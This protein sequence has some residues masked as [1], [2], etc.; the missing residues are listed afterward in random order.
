MNLFI[1]IIKLN[2]TFWGEDGIGK[3]LQRS[4]DVDEI[5]HNT[6]DQSALNLILQFIQFLR[7][8]PEHQSKKKH[9]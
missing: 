7:Q 6:I 9:H 3:L 1:V 2:D 4:A 8:Q 5:G